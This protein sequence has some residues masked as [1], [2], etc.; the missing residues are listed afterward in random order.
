ARGRVLS[1]CPPHRRRLQQAG[2][3]QQAGLD[4]RRTGRP[5]RHR[6]QGSVLR[7]AQMAAFDSISEFGHLARRFTGRQ[8]E[9]IQDWHWFATRCALSMVLLKDQEPLDAGQLRRANAIIDWIEAV[10]EARPG[11]IERYGLNP[12]IHF[13]QA[14]W[15]LDHGH[16][17]YDGFRA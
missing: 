7:F 13:P 4:A 11:Y 12:A 16:G 2:A 5:E 14:V 17:L 8:V 15:A 3:R 10:V 9:R 1:G 6:V